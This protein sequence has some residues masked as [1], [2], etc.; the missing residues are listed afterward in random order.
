VPCY[1][2][3]ADERNLPFHERLGFRVVEAGMVPGSHLRTWALRR[4]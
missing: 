2:E 1:L 3:S 4:D